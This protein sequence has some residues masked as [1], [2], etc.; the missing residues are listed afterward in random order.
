MY[1]AYGQEASITCY[2]GGQKIY[3][4][5]STSKIKRASTGADGY[6]FR[7]KATGRLRE[8]SGDCNIDYNVPTSTQSAGTS[9]QGAAT[10]GKSIMRAP[11]N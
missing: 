5:V 1:D 11:A 8:V 4:G 9:T 2:S 6:Y 3:D 10:A 7:D